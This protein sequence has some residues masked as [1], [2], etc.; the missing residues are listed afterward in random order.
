VA[1]VLIRETQPGDVH[2]LAQNLR[3]SDQAEV[4]ACGEV[5]MHRAVGRSVVASTLCWS[6]F[7]DG[8]LAA[9]LGVSP[10]STMLTGR[11][12][13]WMLGTPVLDRHGR[14]LVRKTPEY[15]AR[16]LTAFPHLINFVHARN[17]TSV[18]WLRRLGFTLYEPVAY[19]PLGEM[20]H[21]FEMRA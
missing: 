8:E 20:F 14:I 18:R 7:V 10:L 13:P 11:G 19:G 17:A 16:M 6:G 9:I 2:L 21:P 3:D 1:D 12:S 15:I 4:R 5:N